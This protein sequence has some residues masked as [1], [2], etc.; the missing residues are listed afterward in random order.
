MK[1]SI[2]NSLVVILGGVKFMTAENEA[3][4]SAL[5]DNYLE[6]RS[7]VRPYEDNRKDMVDKFNADWAGKDHNGAE[8]QK[9]FSMLNKANSTLLDKEVDA[10]I[11]PVALGDFMGISGAKDITLEQVAFLI[12]WGVL[13]K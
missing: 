1:L 3:L 7:F 6:L 10:H 11:T 5:L 9:A 2:A 8:Y 13:K 12:E 4:R